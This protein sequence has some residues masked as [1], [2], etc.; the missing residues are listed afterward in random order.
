MT[1]KKKRQNHNG[2]QKGKPFSEA[3]VGKNVIAEE[4]LNK[5]IQPTRAN[6]SDG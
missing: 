3:A 5:A 2:S 4:D 1:N 6:M